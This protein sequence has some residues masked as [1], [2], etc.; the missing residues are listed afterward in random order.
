MAYTPIGDISKIVRAQWEFFDSGA[1]LS[2]A[3]RR[4]GHEKCV[5]CW[6]RRAD[7][8]ADAEHPA[9]CGRCVSNVSGAGE[10][11]RVI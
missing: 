7:V 8:G 4:S 10:V 1:T 2:I 6:H 3:I 5:R 9:L 11:R